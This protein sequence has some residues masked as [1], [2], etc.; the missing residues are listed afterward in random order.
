M[1]FKPSALKATSENLIA[2]HGSPRV[3]QGIVPLDALLK[4]HRSSFSSTSR[5]MRF[6]RSG[7]FAL[8]E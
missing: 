5:M 1:L 7:Q 2:T 4:L 6:A 8:P 3:A